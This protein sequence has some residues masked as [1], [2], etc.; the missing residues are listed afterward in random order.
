MREVV[1]IRQNKSKWLETEKVISGNIHKNPDELSSLYINLINDL[2]YSQTYYPKSKTTEYLNHLSSQIYQKIYKTKR[3]EQNR[4]L[5][6]FKTEVPLLAYQYRKYLYFSFILF[7]IFTFFGAISTHYDEDFVRLI[8]GDNYVDMTLENIKEGNPIAVYGTGSNWA[9]SV[10]IIRNNL[11]VGANMFFYG[12]FAGFG[13]LYI[14]MKNSIMLGSFQY[15]FQTQ[16]VLGESM[17][18]I[19]I[20]GAFEISGMI[21]EAMAGFIL[22]ASILF[23]KTYSR[24]NSFKIG[25]KDCFKIFIST[26]PFT[27]IAG[28]FEGFVTRHALDMPLILTLFISLGSFGFI[29]FYYVIYPIFVYKKQLKYADL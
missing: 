21:I 8:L 2:S 20:H 29:F 11:F 24:L 7:A 12:V 23:P 25:F 14:L 18:G 4:F 28:I 17:R 1:F 6:F 26:I 9:T 16:G 13:T 19:W 10:L 5:H 15:F 27:T 3:I 22:G